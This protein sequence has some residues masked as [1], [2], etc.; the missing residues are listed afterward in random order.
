[1]QQRF[2]HDKLSDVDARP[3]LQEKNQ[4]KLY[5]VHKKIPPRLNIDGIAKPFMTDKSL[6]HLLPNIA[7]L[8]RFYLTLPCTSCEAERSS[9]CLRRIKTYLRT[10]ITQN[11]LS[12]QRGDSERSLQLDLF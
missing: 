1:M 2:H 4:L 7:I 10:T 6:T 11:R 12:M 5:K 8:I 3:F 9:S